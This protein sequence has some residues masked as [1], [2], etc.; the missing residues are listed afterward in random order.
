MGALLAVPM[1]V[2][3]LAAAEHVPALRP[4]VTLAAAERQHPAAR[5]GLRSDAA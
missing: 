2:A 5:D 4:F 1:T 3:L